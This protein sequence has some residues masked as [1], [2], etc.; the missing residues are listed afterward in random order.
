METNPSGKPRVLILGVSGFLGYHLALHLRTRFSV[1]GICFQ[2]WVQI[3]GVQVYPVASTSLDI[4]EHI[5]RL[6]AP[7]FTVMAAGMNNRQACKDQP[8]LAENFNIVM[9]VSFATVANKIKAKNIHLSCADMYESPHPDHTEDDIEFSL[10]D[11]YA[12][13]KQAAE[14]YI[15]SQTMECTILRLGR[16]LGLGLHHRPSLFDQIR[17]DFLLGETRV[18]AKNR[19]HSWLTAQRLAEAVERVF[20]E[21]IPVKHRTFHVGGAALSEYDLGKSLC[22]ALGWDEKLVKSPGQE[23]DPL[24]FSLSSKLFSETYPGWKPNTERELTD[25]LLQCLRPGL[26]KQPMS[27]PAP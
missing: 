11:D 7:D 20:L 14:S 1:S 5:V 19:V 9:P 21:P 25:Y 24:N 18:M 10:N 17:K 6:Q 3:P 2:H 4:V 13:Q 8:K 15:K 12:K 27:A 26:R 23:E 22:R 16:V